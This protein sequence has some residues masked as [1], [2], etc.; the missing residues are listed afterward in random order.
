MGID[1]EDLV[2]SEKATKTKIKKKTLS[3]FKEKIAMSGKYKMKVQHQLEG[4]ETGNQD[5]DLHI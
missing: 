3:Y 5:S 1:E 2:E 4:K